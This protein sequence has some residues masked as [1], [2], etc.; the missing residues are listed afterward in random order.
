MTNVAIKPKL[1][2]E[3]SQ[4][5]GIPL[6]LNSGNIGL[7]KL[8]LPWDK[9]FSRKTG[10]PEPLIIELHGIKIKTRLPNDLQRAYVQGKRRKLIEDFMQ[11]FSKIQ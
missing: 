9:L 1:M 2:H 6:I 11:Q 10:E 3:L 8:N 4:A 7:I 5:L